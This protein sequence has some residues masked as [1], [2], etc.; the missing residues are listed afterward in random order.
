M[1]SKTDT[2]ISYL[3]KHSVPLAL[4]IFF[5]LGLLLSFTPC[6]LPMLP[7]TVNIIIGSENKNSTSKAVMLVGTYVLSMALC[8][9]VAG[10]A[11]AHL[12]ATIQIWFQ[13]T[14]FIVLIAALITIFAIIQ[15]E[16]I[17]PKLWNFLTNKLH[18]NGNIKSSGT[19]LSVIFI[20]IASA[21]ALSPCA[22]PALIGILTYISQT[23]NPWLGGA[24]LFSMSLGMGTP[25][26][27]IAL[28][29]KQILP[30]AG[31][32]LH[33]IKH[34]TGFALL[35]LVI[36][37]LSRILPSAI[38]SVLWVSLMLTAAVYLQ[39][40]KFS[41]A[42][43]RSAKLEKFIGRSLLVG[44]V[45]FAANLI[46]AE[47]GKH[48]NARTQEGPS[49]GNLHNAASDGKA[50]NLP[51]SQQAPA[52]P[53]HSNSFQSMHTAADLTAALANA[54]Q[55][56]RPV[57]LYFH[58]NWC[59][60]CK[61]LSQAFA[62]LNADGYTK[63]FVLLELDLSNSTAE[64]ERIMASYKIFGLPAVLFFNKDGVEKK[65]ARLSEALAVE[66]LQQHIETAV[67]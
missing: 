22:T 47:P 25:L 24:A 54:K 11:A 15:L 45:L 66:A 57:I 14:W 43:A 36:W 19:F 55:Q 42:K 53:N 4:L 64:S 34:L 20:G 40:F 50:H 33:T 58:A 62:A 7:I 17:S 10:V 9:T 67:E 18:F 3:T 51:T 29:G 13:Q 49:N 1:P 65:H 31:N 41:V 38:I 12:G 21:L 2:V 35:G 6:M 5:A 61:D 46:I 32:W 56:G 8:Y 26:I 44:A 16:L 59:T 60:Y 30:K 28:L 63:Q 37:L 23:G 48:S 27:G 39:A 52:K